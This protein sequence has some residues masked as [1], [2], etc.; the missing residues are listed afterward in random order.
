VADVV[1]AEA[2]EVTRIEPL[3]S[4]ALLL[5]EEFASLRGDETEELSAA[6]IDEELL[7]NLTAGL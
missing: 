2:V 3:A 6:N 7:D 1:R 4:K 5:D